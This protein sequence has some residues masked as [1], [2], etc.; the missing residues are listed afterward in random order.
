M[1]IREE[2]KKKICDLME[3]AF[4]VPMK[5]KELAILMQVAPE[6][7]EEFKS[8]LNEFLSEGKLMI[9]RRGKYQKAEST[10]LTGTFLGNMKGFGFVEV[11]GA[12]ED[13]FVSEKDTLGA[14]H[15]DT[16]EIVP[17][18]SRGGKRKEAKVIRIVAHDIT[19][20]VGTYD[21][22]PG[23]G[24][25]FVIPDNQKLSSDIFV[26]KENAKGAVSGHKVVVEIM[27]YG[28]G[29]KSPEGRITEIIGH[30][31]DP[32]VDIMSI[33]K[34]F[35]LPVE[36]SE[37]VMNQVENVAKP[38]SAGDVQGRL[39]LRE[40]QMVTIDGEDAK[41]L[42]DAVSLEFDGEIYH[43]GVHIADVSNYV[44]ENSALDREA[45][46]RGTSVYLVDRV[47]PMLPHALSNGICSLNAGED[48]L[49][50]S[51]LMSINSRGQ[52]IDYD[53]RETVIRVDERMSYT[54]VKNILEQESIV[55]TDPDYARYAG[56]VPMF[57][58]MK[59]LSAILR[60][61]RKERGSIDFDLPECKILLDKEGNPLEIKPYER[62]VATNLIEDFM[63]AANETVAQHFYW[64][65]VPFVYRVH[66]VPDG[67]RMKQLVLL[68]QNMG[69]YMKTVGRKGQKT[70]SEEIHPKEVQKLIEKIAGTPEETM[71]T[72]FILRSMQQAKYSVENSGHFGLACKYYCHFTSPIR[73]YP[74]LQIHRIIKEQLRG[75]LSEERKHHYL[76]L[77]P[78]VAKQSS[79]MER[80]ADEAE[81]E[82]EKLKKVQYMEAHIGEEFE[83]IISSV[84]AWGMYV[85]LPNTVEGMI[86]I[87]KLT[88]DYYIYRENTC[89][90]VGE[91][92][93]RI[94]KI[95]MSVKIRVEDCD[96]FAKT[97]DFSLV[98]E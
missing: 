72:R 2:R 23:K 70:G 29:R 83:G 77:L 3:D 12:E 38:V 94:Y 34:G 33:V 8:I 96:R 22:V 40:L 75:K 91:A 32:G 62:N 36:F 95:G 7:R 65:E 18:P 1:S 76:E 48:R 43:L 4:Y 55:E 44:Q 28:N 56:L 15:K 30:I 45:K 9:T 20:L 82:T 71:I 98:M 6:E 21:S 63:L 49:A 68:L 51:C 60:K 17:I 13:F 35:E 57:V 87:S 78:E 85:E 11:E 37:R 31:N 14:F 24:Y 27:D 80:R 5:E 84:T 52:I 53:I 73:R 25:G 79:S 61:K 86:H 66:G 74:D 64:L 10:V 16:V 92:T 50:L 93:G 47:I 19:T 81:R 89:E 97:I 69:Y 90:L 46:K 67:D 39:D 59:E 54:A 88:G 58:L 26:S 42:D 41:D